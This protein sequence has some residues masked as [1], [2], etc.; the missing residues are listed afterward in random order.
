MVGCGHKN[1]YFVHV[2]IFPFIIT[3]L[4]SIYLIT[5]ISSICLL[6]C[7]FIL[8]LAEYYVLI[9]CYFILINQCNSLYYEFVFIVMVSIV[10]FM[11][12]E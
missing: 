3:N 10:D 5:I 7:G 4:I 9:Y 8:F 6:H 12:L 2:C 11:V 1:G